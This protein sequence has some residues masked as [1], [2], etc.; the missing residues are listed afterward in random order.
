MEELDIVAAGYAG[1]AGAACIAKE[2]FTEML[3]KFRKDYAEHLCEETGC[4]QEDHAA[5]AGSSF[6]VREEGC[7]CIPVEK[8]GILAALY[9][10]AKE[11]KCGLRIALKKIPVRQDTI[12]LCEMYG[13]N[14]YRLYSRCAVYL[15][16]NGE[17]LAEELREQ[18]I[19]AERIGRLT[20]GLDKVITDKTETEYL[21]R[22]EPD[23]LLKALPEGNKYLTL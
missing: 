9:L 2:R 23:E 15:C 8:G 4:R 14:P 11:R 3:R 18:G 1:E 12:E 20:K 7:T 22:P 10:A 6:A 16:K 17:R 19:P 5:E 13:L 21:N